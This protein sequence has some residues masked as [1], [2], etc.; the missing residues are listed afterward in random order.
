MLWNDEPEI[1]LPLYPSQQE[2]SLVLGYSP[3]PL[4]LCDQNFDVLRP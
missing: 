4:T 1:D 3:P 2:M